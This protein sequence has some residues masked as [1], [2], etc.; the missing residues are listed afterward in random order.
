M[1]RATI[2]WFLLSFG[3]AIGFDGSTAFADPPTGPILE[4]QPA[5]TG[6]AGPQRLSQSYQA[7]IRGGVGSA[8]PP[9]NLEVPLPGSGGVVQVPA[10][11][12][13]SDT[14]T[15]CRP[16]TNRFKEPFQRCCSIRNGFRSCLDRY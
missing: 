15:G 5:G 12:A 7:P 9:S 1:K 11:V 14:W 16:Y 13:A 3:L 8:R 10:T 4:S 2:A 6:E